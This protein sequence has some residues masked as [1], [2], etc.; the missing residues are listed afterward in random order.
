[1]SAIDGVVQ[2]NLQKKGIL[3]L[4]IVRVDNLV[5]QLYETLN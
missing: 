4:E 3:V 5:P 1:V 2:R